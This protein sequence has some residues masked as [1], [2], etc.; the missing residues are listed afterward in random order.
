MGLH[1]ITYKKSFQRNKSIICTVPLILRD[2]CT[3]I[4]VLDH[5]NIP[6]S[7]VT[8]NCV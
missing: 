3:D 5:F 8:I 2:A 6:Y 4:E 7:K 1:K